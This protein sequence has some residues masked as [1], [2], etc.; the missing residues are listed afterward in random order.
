MRST[1]SPVDSDQHEAPIAPDIVPADW[2][3][4]VPRPAND[5]TS[6]EKLFAEIRLAA[7]TAAPSVDNT[8]RASDV[9]DHPAM[10]DKAR[11][12]AWIKRALTVFTLALLGALA[13]AAWQHH[14]DSAQQTV[15][16]WMPMP[17]EN[18]LPA[19]AADE[20]V[21][22]QQTAP[23]LS[24]ADAAAPPALPLEAERKIQSMARDLAA[25]G[26]QIEQLKATIETLKANQQATV[27][28]GVRAPAPQPPPKPRATIAPRPAS[29]PPAPTYS[30]P[31]QA[32]AVSPPAP[33]PLVPAPPPPQAT[34]QPNGEPI[35]R[36]PMPL[37]LSDRY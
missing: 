15:A 31:A 6:R 22:E 30:P 34:T 5:A 33:A 13:T 18:S 16:S 37:P 2:A 29:V 32:A 19:K 8:F 25:M 4:C 24:P 26:Q 9:S 36:P 21:A 14:G 20:P 12:R 1:L 28:P 11:S 27:A 35:V 7:E 23:A 3:D 10:K 17:A